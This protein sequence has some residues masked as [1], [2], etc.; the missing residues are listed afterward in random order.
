MQLPARHCLRR[1]ARRRCAQAR[2]RAASSL[3]VLLVLLEQG[4]AGWWPKWPSAVMM[5]VTHGVCQTAAE[6]QGGAGGATVAA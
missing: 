1:S 2:K 6:P 3:L 5:P 4:L